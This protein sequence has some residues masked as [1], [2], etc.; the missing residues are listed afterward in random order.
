MAQPP[1]IWG[2]KCRIF[3]INWLPLYHAFRRPQVFC[4]WTRTC[5]RDMKHLPSDIWH[6]DYVGAWELVTPWWQS[7]K[8]WGLQDHSRTWHIFCLGFHTCTVAIPLCLWG[9]HVFFQCGSPYLLVKLRVFVPYLPLK[10]CAVGRI[11]I[12][13]LLM[14]FVHILVVI[15]YPLFNVLPI[16]IY[17]QKLKSV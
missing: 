5:I 14:V 12:V 15:L 9:I 4:C 7:P 3:R 13:P 2:Y 11:P 10:P 6:L 1:C 17:Y 16:L 8:T